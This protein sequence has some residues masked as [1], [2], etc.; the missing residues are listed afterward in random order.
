MPARRLRSCIAACALA[1]VLANA[2]AARADEV[3]LGPDLS[4]LTGP[5][6]LQPA[7]GPA[8]CT[9]LQSSGPN[10][11]SPVNGLITSWSF[12]TYGPEGS[13]FRLRV[14]RGPAALDQPFTVLRSTPLAP[15]VAAEGV[16]EDVASLPIAAGDR[17]ALG[18]LA[19][20]PGLAFVN[21]PGGEAMLAWATGQGGPPDG[22]S[23]TPN[24]ET[25]GIVGLSAIV[26]YC[27]VPKAKGKKLKAAKRRVRE[28]GCRPKPKRRKAGDSVPAKKLGRVY[29]QKPAPG[30]TVAPGTPVKLFFRR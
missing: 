18:G 2:S 28:A 27:T 20:S 23:A 26:S 15:S 25:F 16:H 4:T 1:A 10:S 14:V 8:A 12:R 5:L 13:E 29:K 6:G 7:C 21:P 30:T 3:T 17:I 9:F 22:G 24:S 19:G 11:V